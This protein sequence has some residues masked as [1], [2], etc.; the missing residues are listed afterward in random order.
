MKV[1]T[2]LF[3]NN[4]DDTYLKYDACHGGEG[5]F[6]LKDVIGKVK[7]KQYIKYL[8]DDILPPGSAFGD[9]AHTSNEPV[10]E[11]YFCLAGE[12]VMTLDGKPHAMK[13]GDISACYANGSHGLRNTG[14]EDMRILVIGI[15]PV[16]DK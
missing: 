1:P 10:E 8:H 7:D 4:Q 5:P 3:V 15:T 11:W 16:P 14:Q 6:L 2:T 12:G 9:H 13:A